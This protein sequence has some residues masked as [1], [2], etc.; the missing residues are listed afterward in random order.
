MQMVFQMVKRW[1]IQMGN[2]KVKHLVIQ[3]V[4]RLVIQMVNHLEMHLVKH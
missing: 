3:M 4:K 1:E 2:Q